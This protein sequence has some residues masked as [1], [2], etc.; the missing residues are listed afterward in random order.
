[1]V[2]NLHYVARRPHYKPR[3]TPQVKEQR[4]DFAR[5][6]LGVTKILWRRCVFTDETLIYRVSRESNA[7]HWGPKNMDFSAIQ[8]APMPRGGGGHIMISACIS[9][10]GLC[11]VTKIEGNMTA[12]IYRRT[13]QNGLLDFIGDNFPDGN[14]IFIQD[15]APVHTA[16]AVL[17]WLS[18]QNFG[19]WRLPPYSP[20]LNP[21]ENFWPVFKKAV[22]R[23]GPAASLEELKTKI[24]EA[25][26]EFQTPNGIEM[27]RRF[28]DS[29]PNRMQAVVA[30]HGG[31]SKY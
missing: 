22:R 7:F 28:I 29:M 24:D 25:V 31:E 23:R 9:Y 3:I 15:N 11:A 16:H 18:E 27:V 21:I 26:A 4:L 30:K 19:R 8:D 5:A 2:H 14:A 17:E 6:R 20:D 10:F 12:A 1:M 13:L